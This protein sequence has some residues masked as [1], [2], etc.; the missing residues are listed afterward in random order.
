MSSPP[1]N[2]TLSATDMW[3][4]GWGINIK[5]GQKAQGSTLA[6]K[7]LADQIKASGEFSIEAWMAPSNVAQ[8]DA[9]AV[10]YSA[11]KDG[12]QRHAGSACLSVR[13]AW[14]AATRPMGTVSRRC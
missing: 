1:L 12:A 4:G 5:P 7:K 9:Y 2:L 10:S 13:S 6:S 14:F 8:E 3:V 11:G